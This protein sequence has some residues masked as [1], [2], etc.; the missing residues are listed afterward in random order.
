LEKPSKTGGGDYEKRNALPKREKTRQIGGGGRIMKNEMLS[1]LLD[2]KICFRR[3][4]LLHFLLNF[5]ACKELLMTGLVHY[6]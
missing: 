4:Q 5:G 1:L 6:H 2:E 3:L